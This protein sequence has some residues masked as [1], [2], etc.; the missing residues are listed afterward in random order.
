[1]D[2]AMLEIGGRRLGPGSPCLVIAEAGV[3]HNGDLDR[4]L[5]MVETAARCGADAVKFQSFRAEEIVTPQAPKAAYQLAATDQAQSQLE[6]LKALEL[7]A[8]QHRRLSA[9]CRRH[10]VIFLSTPFDALSAD[11]L[12]DLGVPAFKVPSGEITNLPLLAHLGAKNLPVILSTGMAGM[13]EVAEAIRALGLAGCPSLA[14][15]HCLSNYPAD[16]A[17]VNLRAMATMAQAFGLPVGYSDHTLG[18]EV[19]LAAVALGACIIEKHFTLDRSLPGPDHQASATPGELAALVRG[20]RTVEAA[21]GHGRKEPA[22]SE[23]AVAA[24][25]R[26]SLV[27]ARDIAGGDVLA[28]DMLACRRPGNGLTPAQLELV[29][30]RR[31]AKDIAAGTLIS[32]E[33]LA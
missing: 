21:L 28:A 15:L 30:G 6:M 17:Q 33:L 10:C 4:A 27:A 3:N 16:P 19:A 32:L 14:L 9:H 18:P 24:V 11:L 8:E 13:E 7:S 1:M 20:I 2:P 26:R 31:A 23:A 29:L 25:A 12:A 5:A 22:A